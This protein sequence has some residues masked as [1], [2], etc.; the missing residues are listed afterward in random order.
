MTL[1]RL[2]ALLLG[3]CAVSATAAEV[4]SPVGSWQLTSGESRY[5]VAECGGDICARLVWLRDDVRTEENLALLNT[6]VVK[7]AQVREDKW[8]GTAIHEGDVVEASVTMVD[9]NTMKLTGCKLFCK[10]MT[11]AR[12]GLD[13]AAK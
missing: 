7:G 10:T 13:I 8:Q 2:T 1:F 12:V 3:F 6:V 4:A 11:L 5:D 9:G